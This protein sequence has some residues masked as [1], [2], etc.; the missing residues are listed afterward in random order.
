M[1]WLEH[2]LHSF[3]L[4]GLPRLSFHSE[5]GLLDSLQELA[6]EEQR[7]AEQVMT[8]LLSNELARRRF[9]RENMRRWQSLSPREQQVAALVCLNY[10]NPQISMRLGISS[11]TV[12][13]HVR[14]LLTKFGLHSR[15]ELRQLLVD[16]DFSA[17]EK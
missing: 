13:S 16:W 6:V 2:L 9:T 17:W 8:D 12:K 1:S 14:N 5:Q 15:I 3:G 4:R 11:Q 7:P 10:T